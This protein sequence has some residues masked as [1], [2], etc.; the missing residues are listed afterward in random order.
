M[1][2]GAEVSARIMEN[3]LEY[4]DAPVQRVASLDVPMP[5][6]RPLEQAVM[7]DEDRVIEAVYRLF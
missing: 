7:P 4:L 2:I 5:Y 3:A 6:A 1:G